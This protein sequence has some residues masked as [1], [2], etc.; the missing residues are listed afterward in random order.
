[1]PIYIIECKKCG[2]ERELILTAYADYARIS[3]IL[4]CDRCH[5]AGG[6]RRLPT[7]ANISFKGNGWSK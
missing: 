1:M 7:A 3:R 5:T 2:Y 6:W 4:E